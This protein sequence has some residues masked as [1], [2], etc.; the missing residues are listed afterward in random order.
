MHLFSL[1]D[2]RLTRQGPM[3]PLVGE[4]NAPATMTTRLLPDTFGFPLLL[5]FH[6]RSMQFT[7]CIMGMIR[8]TDVMC[9][10]AKV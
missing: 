6:L 4:A 5:N 2:L 3:T 7:Y 10:L 8:K 1:S 9:L